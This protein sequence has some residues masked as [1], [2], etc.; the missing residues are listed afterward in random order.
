MRGHRRRYKSRLNGQH[1]HTG[2]IDA[3]THAIEENIKAALGCPIDVVALAAPIPGDRRDHGDRSATLGL[4]VIREPADQ[5]NRREKICLQNR[6]GRPC[7]LGLE[8]LAEHAVRQQSEVD[9]VQRRH[10]VSQHGRVTAGIVEVRGI[11]GGRGRTAREQVVVNRGQLSWIS[12]NQEEAGMLFREQAQRG[13]G[14]GGG[15]AKGQ[16]APGNCALI[17]HRAASFP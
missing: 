16:H 11:G 13:F 3:I 2:A 9:P 6:L 12:A 8:H 4:E 14:N 1:L 5:R 15:R 7:D 17:R 10:R